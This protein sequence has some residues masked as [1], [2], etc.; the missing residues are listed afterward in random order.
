MIGV[1]KLTELDEDY[2]YIK[3]N[4]Y[5]YSTG[6]SKLK[7]YHAYFWLNDFESPDVSLSRQFD[8][9]FEDETMGIIN[10]RRTVSDGHY[11]DLMGNAVETPHKG[12]YLKDGKKVV[13]K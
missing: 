9:K 4:T 6:K 10:N 5:K 11:Y 2:L 7:P 8:I 1:Y 3:D 13:V 12:I